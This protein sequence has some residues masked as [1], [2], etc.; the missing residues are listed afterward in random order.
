MRRIL[1]IL[2][3]FLSITACRHGCGEVPNVQDELT[4]QGLSDEMWTYFSFERGEV[5]GQSRFADEDED[6]AWAARDD[7]DLALCGEYLKTNGGTSGEGA[8]GI[9][10]DRE[11]TFLSLEEAPAEGY[12]LDEYQKVL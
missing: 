4:L 9:R 11:H 10:R 12:V 3:C 8:G 7:W 2:I 5:V 6:A 1:L